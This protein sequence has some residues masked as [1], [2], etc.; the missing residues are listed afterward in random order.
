M[1]KELHGSLSLKIATLLF[2]S[3]PF[4]H[5]TNASQVRTLLVFPRAPDETTCVRESEV[6]PPRRLLPPLE[7]DML[8]PAPSP[9][10]PDHIFE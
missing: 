9:R 3:L 1:G 8:L 2:F 7:I 4:Q 5:S 6:E 10:H